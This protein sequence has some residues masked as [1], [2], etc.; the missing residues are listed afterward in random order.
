MWRP[1]FEFL[2]AQWAWI[3][4]WRRRFWQGSP[5]HRG[6]PDRPGRVVT[7]VPGG[8]CV[9]IAYRVAADRRHETLAMLDHRERGGY[10]QREVAI[11]I[12]DSRMIGVTYIATPDNEHYLGPAPIHRI[13]AEVRRAVGPS[14]RNVDYLREL[15]QVLHA[16]PATDAHVFALARLACQEYYKSMNS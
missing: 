12:R 14:G 16:I 3:E 1:G 10:Q 11:T 9:G 15:A 5:D 13:S 7:L 2:E 6:T 4:G 8:C